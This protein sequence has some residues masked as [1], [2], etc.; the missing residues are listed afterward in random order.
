MTFDNTMTVCEYPG[1]TNPMQ[2][3]EFTCERHWYILPV[4]IRSQIYA[5]YRENEE[6]SE[7][8]KEVLKQAREHLKKRAAIGRT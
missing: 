7:Q 8:L 4:A 6:P 5:L 2:M 1:C 3:G